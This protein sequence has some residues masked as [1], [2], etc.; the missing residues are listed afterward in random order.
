MYASILEIGCGF[1]E[2][3]C[4]QENRSLTF[5]DPPPPPVLFA[6]SSMPAVIIP[7]LHVKEL[8]R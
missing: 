1:F 8:G 6:N 3:A 5:R 7:S 2:G 4:R